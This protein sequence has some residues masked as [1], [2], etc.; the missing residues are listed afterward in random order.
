MKHCVYCCRPVVGAS[1]DNE[2]YFEPIC[3]SCVNLECE[4]PATK[5]EFGTTAFIVRR[6]GLVFLE[7]R[8]ADGRRFLIGCVDAATDL[9]CEPERNWLRHSEP[10]W[11]ITF[12]P[13]AESLDSRRSRGSTPQS[14]V[15]CGATFE[16]EAGVGQ[17]I[18]APACPTCYPNLQNRSPQTFIGKVAHQ[19]T[20]RN[21]R[22]FLEGTEYGTAIDFVV[23][24]LAGPP[25]DWN[26][27]P[28]YHRTTD[29]SLVW[30]C[31]FRSSPA[32]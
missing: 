10:A 18:D 19:F 26:E 4:G 8:N 7:G 14:C 2:M 16:C 12:L 1:A 22:W 31:E 17:F 21:G 3:A 24:E 5:L 32:K 29:G 9:N 20:E 13:T 30:E 25:K 28:K 11:D 6:G 15:Y 27:P 23:G